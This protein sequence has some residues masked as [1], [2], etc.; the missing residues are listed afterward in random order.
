MPSEPRRAREVVKWMADPRR[1]PVLVREE[2]QRLVGWCT[3]FGLR[4]DAGVEGEGPVADRVGRRTRC[5]QRGTS[6]QHKNSIATV[7][8]SPSN[9]SG[10][11]DLV[12]NERKRRLEP[13]GESMV[14]VSVARASSRCVHPE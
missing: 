8:G 11:D 7:P 4:R 12:G 14:P 3:Q 2:G 6:R 1:T 10:D 5:C 13:G 9:A